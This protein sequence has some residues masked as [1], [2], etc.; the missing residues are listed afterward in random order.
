[1]IRRSRSSN[2]T[3]NRDRS[4]RPTTPPTRATSP[5]APARSAKRSARPS[6]S[7]E[8]RSSRCRKRGVHDAES[9]LCLLRSEWVEAVVVVLLHDPTL[10]ELEQHAE[11]RSERKT[12]HTA[13]ASDKPHSSG[14]KRKKKR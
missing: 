12:H 8:T 2:N 5:T 10:A 7:Q 13:D 1:M 3:P 11:P 4:A 6:R 9:A 14:K